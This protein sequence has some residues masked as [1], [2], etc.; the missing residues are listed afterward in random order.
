[1][2][3]LT[4]TRWSKELELPIVQQWKDES[5]YK[6]KHNPQ[7][8]I[9][10]IDTPPP[11]I[12]APVHIGH[13]S[14]Y[15]IMDMFARYKR[16]TGHN[17]IFPL[18]MDRNGLPIEMAAEKKY[19][20]RLHETPREKFLEYCAQMLKE[21]G[22]HSLQTFFH[23]GIGFNEWKVGEEIGQ[24]YETDSKEY[25]TLTQ[26]TFIDL[27]HKG[28]VYEAKR[29]N[30]YCPGCRTTLSDSE[31]ERKEKET[32][33]NEVVFVE[34]STKEKL[35]IATTRPELL[36]TA[37]VIIYNP[38]DERYQ[39]LKDKKAI[40][41][42]YGFEIPII[43][44][45]M[46]DPNFGTGLAY[47]SRSAGDTEAIRFLIEQG[48]EAQGCIDETGRMTAEAGFLQ[49][50]KTKEAREKIIEKIREE[51]LLHAQKKIM[52]SVPICERSKDQIEFISMP[53]LYVKQ[54]HVK[55]E[56]KKIADQVTFYSPESKQI[57][58]DWIANVKIDWPIS[59]RRYYGTEIPLW[60]CGKCHYAFVPPKG[61]YH[62]P[63]KDPC[64]IEECPECHSTEWKG[65]TRVF[66]TWFDSSNSAAY[67]LGKGRKDDF[68]LK[69]MPCTLR[70]QGKEIVRTWLYYSLLKHY[71]LHHKPLFENAFIHNHILDGKGIKMSKS[72]GNVIDPAEILQKFGAEPFRLWVG[73]EGNLSRT[74]LMCSMERIEGAGKT[75]TKFWNVA[76][77]VSGFKNP[78]GQIKLLPA[79]EWVLMELS[80]LIQTCREG[81]ERYDVFTPSTQLRYFLWET[82][83]SHY[84]ELVKNRAYNEQGTFSSEEQ[85][86]A[87]YTLH[88][89][90][91][92]LLQL[93]APIIPIFTSYLY[94]ALHEQ[95]VHFTSYP[96]AEHQFTVL[97][98]A[99][100]LMQANSAIWKAK[101]E[102]G[103]SLKAPIRKAQLPIA[104][105]VIEKDLQIAHSIETITYGSHVAIEL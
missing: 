87:L 96:E 79:D 28:L 84:L 45:T 67:I 16:M 89:C 24:M 80:K 21:A 17:V 90:L 76:R 15:V 1:M 22:T 38:A 102:K 12:N 2:P 98:S 19:N 93:Y 74:D 97:F 91:D 13:A 49:G 100:D 62:Q 77:F 66:D 71:L 48:I 39:H 99:E 72:L 36:C 86:G 40:V 32:F 63:W 83:A 78:E 43:P 27:W 41:P 103:L 94:T 42:V 20:I 23:A 7:L 64:P 81:F 92:T 57:L 53:E 8:P 54:L 4:E 9:F 73:M 14:T 85:N 10:S 34:T 50:L 44:H 30:N 33:L 82:F 95:D 101:K 70:P 55:E 104:L 52:H 25:R 37:A 59:R 69:H 56:M 46:A 68:F 60:Y 88:Y 31:I 29:L 3:G 51:G 18:G 58:T 65:E 75:L 11:Y 47:M 5:A 26:D 61:K 105:K 35:V 6:F